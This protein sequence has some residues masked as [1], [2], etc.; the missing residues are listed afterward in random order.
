MHNPSSKFLAVGLLT[1]IQWQH[2]AYK[3]NKVDENILVTH[4]AL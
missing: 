2:N 3:L 4:L 1:T